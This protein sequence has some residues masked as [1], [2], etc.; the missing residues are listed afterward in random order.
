M[1]PRRALLS[2]KIIAIAALLVA[3]FP[4]AET[5]ATC[6]QQ[7]V[8]S[9]VEPPSGSSQTMFEVYGDNLDVAG[10]IT[11]TNVG[12]QLGIENL[13]VSA[14]RILFTVDDG[15]DGLVSFNLDPDDGDCES[16]SIEICLVLIGKNIQKCHCGAQ[17]ST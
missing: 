1:D 5:Q 7:P 11:I 3:R 15:G 12:G 13:N 9:T 14:S 16:V 17:K 8:I 6:S 2:L 10:S 4:A